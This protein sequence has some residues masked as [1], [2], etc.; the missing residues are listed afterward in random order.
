MEIIM[1]NSTK[2]LLGALALVALIVVAT[3]LYDTLGSS[4]EGGGLVFKDSISLFKSL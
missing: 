2:W 3:V 1:K 4:F